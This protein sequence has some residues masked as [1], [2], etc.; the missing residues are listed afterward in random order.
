MSDNTNITDDDFMNGPSS[1]ED[2]SQVDLEEEREHLNQETEQSDFEEINADDEEGISTDYGWSDFEA[3]DT[4]DSSQE[5]VHDDPLNGVSDDYDDDSEFNE[6]DLED[7]YSNILDQ[8]DDNQNQSSAP[9]NEN[10]IIANLK[11]KGYKIEAPEDEDAIRVN[12]I[13]QLDNVIDGLSNILSYDDNQIIRI[14]LTNQLTKEYN[15]KGQAQKINSSDFKEELEE[16]IS[17]MN[18]NPSFKNMYVDTQKQGIQ[19][20][21][22]DKTAQRDSLKQQHEQALTEKLNSLKAQTRK[23]VVDLS[24]K[25]GLNK[26]DAKEVYSFMNSEEFKKIVDDPNFVVRSVIAELAERKGKRLFN[27]DDNYS[28]GVKDTLDDIRSNGS[29]KS[30]NSSFGK[31]I[32][33][34]GNMNPNRFEPSAWTSA[35]RPSSNEEDKKQKPTRRVAGRF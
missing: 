23:T 21:I 16:R 4:S 14:A 29:A 6:L 8:G 11:A 34:R 28:R 33:G 7:D 25:Y 35:I 26:N 17:D 1:F 9:S 32:S 24:K 12:G 27:N 5:E 3:V 10:E 18:L 13:N 2:Y 15:D 22:K 31:Q 19:N 30:S 20:L